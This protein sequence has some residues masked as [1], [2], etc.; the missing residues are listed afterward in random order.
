MTPRK[1]AARQLH[2]LPNIVGYRFVGVYHDGSHRD[3]VVETDA[4]GRHTFR[5]WGSVRGWL[6]L[7][8]HEAFVAALREAKS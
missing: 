8:E 4:A 2:T 5:D 3:C 6:T 7:G 1:R